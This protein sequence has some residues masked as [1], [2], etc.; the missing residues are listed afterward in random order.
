MQ[1]M[2]LVEITPNTYSVDGS[3]T[4]VCDRQEEGWVVLHWFVNQY[5]EIECLSETHASLQAAADSAAAH[6]QALR[7]R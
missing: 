7:G 2:T 5:G 1:A 4:L 6:L 3:D